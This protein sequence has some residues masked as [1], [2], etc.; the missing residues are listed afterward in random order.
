MYSTGERERKWSG[1]ITEE[2]CEQEGQ[3]SKSSPGQEKERELQQK[4]PEA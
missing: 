2:K 3:V 4:C 1:E